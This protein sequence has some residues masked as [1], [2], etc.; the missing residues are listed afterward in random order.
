MKE[1]GIPWLGPTLDDWDITAIKREFDVY[2]GATPDSKTLEYWDG[3]VIWITPADFKTQD[4]YVI[5]GKRNLSKAGYKACGT[6]IVPAGSIIFSKRAPIG[7]VCIST[8]PMCTNQGCL[9]CVPKTDVDVKY[10]Y[11][12]MSTASEAFEVEGS[13]TTFKEISLNK[14]MNFKVPVPSANEQSMMVHYLD[15]RVSKINSIITEVQKSIEE[16]K[17]LK[18]AVITEAVTKGLD[19]N[20]P[21]KDSGIKSIGSIPEH[22]EPVHLKN[23]CTKISD[24]SHFSPNTFSDGF[25]YITA[26]NVH[27][28]GLDYN[29]AKRISAEDFHNLEQAGCRP[30]KG[31][32][33]L[34]KDGATTGRVGLMTDNEPCV[35][36]SSVA[37]LTP[38]GNV[39]SKYLMYL[40]EANAIQ[41]QIKVSMAG[42]AMPRTVLSKIVNYYGIWCPR[43]EQI[44]IADMLDGRTSQIDA[45]I[46]EKQ[47]LIDDLQEYKKSL[48]Y[49]VVTG[50]RKVVSKW[51]RTRNSLN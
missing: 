47:S 49:E 43:N 33:L 45:L 24:G 31:D 50:K 34:V 14:F 44:E 17:T 9:S 41:E 42:S 15:P 4:Q 19:K 29:E 26:A 28:E 20:A 6:T 37:Y 38:R 10:Y 5:S 11:Y 2:A 12:V 35:L 1:T 23:L 46:F 27:G 32:V 3:D 21:M 13:G 16:Y 40:L 8:Q 51:P 36:L 22:W 25:C 39:Y 18:Q 30:H 48:I 7:T